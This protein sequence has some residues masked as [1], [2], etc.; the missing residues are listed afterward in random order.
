MAANRIVGKA[1]LYA[2]DDVIN[3]DDEQLDLFSRFMERADDPDGLLCRLDG[4][5]GSDPSA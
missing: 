1:R 4:V 5:R 2:E 3:R